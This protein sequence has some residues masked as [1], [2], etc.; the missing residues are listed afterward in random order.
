MTGPNA[1]SQYA[2]SF[3]VRSSSMIGWIF[4][5]SAA[6]A[7]ASAAPALGPDE[8]DEIDT[9]LDDLRTR[10]E[11]I[12]QWEFCDGFLT[13][14]ICSRRPIPPSEYLPM[15]LGMDVSKLRVTS[16][17]IGGGFGGN[18]GDA[19]WIIGAG[20]D[21]GAGRVGEGHG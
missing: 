7:S 3:A 9:L 15:L 2:A 18:G 17:E 8:L 11:E 20:G 19:G 14:L 6:A 16:S 1:Q 12:P 10:G 4:A 5:K 21:G 13:A